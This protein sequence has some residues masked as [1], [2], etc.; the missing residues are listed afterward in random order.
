MFR[1]LPIWAIVGGRVAQGVTHGVVQLGHC[2][3][4]LVAPAV[5]LTSAHCVEVVPSEVRTF[6]QRVKVRDCRSEPGYESARA[7]HDLAVCQLD[8]PLSDAPVPLEAAPLDVGVP[9]KLAG[10]G[11]TGA[12]TRDAGTLRTVDARVGK[13]GPFT[14]EAG[15]DRATS[16]RGDSGGPA[17]VVR[18][19]TFAVAG[20]IHGGAGAICGSPTELVP[21]RSHREWLRT[22]LAPIKSSPDRL[23]TDWVGVTGRGIYPIAAGVGSALALA[24]CAHA[25]I[26]KYRKGSQI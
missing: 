16:C 26:R 20:I 9:L 14:V 11:Q 10:Y 5:V 21:V 19:A 23:M 24:L 2:S 6:S 22:E 25:G 18:G 7:F 17:F 4:V 3:G 13:V 15:T 12:I 1:G 8:L